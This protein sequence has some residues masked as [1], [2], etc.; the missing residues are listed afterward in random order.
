MY[1]DND[2]ANSVNNRVASVR[3]E[4]ALHPADPPGQSAACRQ[5]G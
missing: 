4:A 1:S 3:A 5:G 2:N